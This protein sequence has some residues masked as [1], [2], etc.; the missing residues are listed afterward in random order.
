[1]K[2]T[3]EPYQIKRIVETYFGFSVSQNTRLRPIAEARFIYSALCRKYTR[4]SFNEIGQLVG[5]DHSSILYGASQTITLC[6][7][8]EK[9]RIKFENIDKLVKELK[10]NPYKKTIIN[11]PKK[12]HP[13]LLRY[14]QKPLRQI[15]NKR[16]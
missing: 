1:M 4:A 16:R 12:I 10:D 6:Q 5:R 2:N 3:I 13:Y 9:F 14:A 11:Q 7:Y 15:L 8:D